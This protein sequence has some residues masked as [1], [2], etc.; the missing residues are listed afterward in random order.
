MDKINEFMYGL[1]YENG[2]PSLTRTLY[3]AAFLLCVGIIVFCAFSPNAQLADIAKQILVIILGAK[4]ADKV[5]TYITN[6]VSN[7]PKGEKPDTTKNG[8][9]EG[10]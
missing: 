10:V 7:S 4:T 6:S 1:L 5:V 2:E 9:Q 8:G 3:V